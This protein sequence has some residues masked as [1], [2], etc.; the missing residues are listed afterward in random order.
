MVI[1]NPPPAEKPKGA[2]AL[3]PQLNTQWMQCLSLAKALAKS[4]VELSG[5][6]NNVYDLLGDG[7]K[8]TEEER[9]TKFTEWTIIHAPGICDIADVLFD[10]KW[11]EGV[12]TAKLSPAQ[13]ARLSDI[14]TLLDNVT[15]FD[16]DGEPE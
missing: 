16:L 14:L 8:L 13:S 15:S 12:S 6:L 2:E 10:F 5:T 1:E 9:E 11:C 7:E 4:C 3:M